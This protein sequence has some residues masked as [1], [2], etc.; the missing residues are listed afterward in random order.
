[1]KSHKLKKK[2]VKDNSDRFEFSDDG[3]YIRFKNINLP[4]DEFCRL[5]DVTEERTNIFGHDIKFCGLRLSIFRKSPVCATCE[6][7]G[8]HF[9]LELG[10]LND[11]VPHLNFYGKDAE[12]GELLFTKDHVLP[13]S[14]GGKNRLENM[15]TMCVTCNSEKG[16]KIEG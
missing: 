6:A 9:H 5:F 4:Y 1:M 13:K 8:T 7:I 11:G 3:H 15:Q 2:F 12:G 10:S 14:K 16:N